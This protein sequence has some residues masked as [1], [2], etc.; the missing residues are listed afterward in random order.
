LNS[1]IQTKKALKVQSCSDTY[2][3]IYFE[4]CRH[5]HLCS[6]EFAV[7]TIIC[8]AGVWQNVLFY[9][10]T[11]QSEVRKLITLMMMGSKC[12]PRFKVAFCD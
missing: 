7:R 9:V 1:E 6:R 5:G 8:F 2:M 11:I 3:V 12:L 4:N 10:R